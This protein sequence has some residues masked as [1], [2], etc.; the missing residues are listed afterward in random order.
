MNE[1]HPQSIAF[2]TKL[3]IGRERYEV[4]RITY[5]IDLMLQQDLL[6]RNQLHLCMQYFF[7]FKNNLVQTS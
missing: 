6:V 7:H 4:G 5:W 2:P 1:S 3:T